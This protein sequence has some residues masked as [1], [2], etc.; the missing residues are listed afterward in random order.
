MYCDGIQ[1]ASGDGYLACTTN[2]DCQFLFFC[3]GANCGNCEL[4]QRRR[5]FLDPLEA[6]GSA[7]TEGDELVS[8][9]CGGLLSSAGKN[10]AFGLPGPIRLVTDWDFT[11]YCPDG[12]TPWEIGGANCP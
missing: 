5:C 1:R 11:A 10:A 12:I 8:A 2:D 6:T 7:S 4:A 9:Y 3:P